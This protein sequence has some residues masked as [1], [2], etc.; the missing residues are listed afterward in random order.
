VTKA[1]D[2]IIEYVD[3]NGTQK[4]GICLDFANTLAGSVLMLL[5][6]EFVKDIVKVFMGEDIKEEELLT[7]K[8]SRSAIGE[9]AN[10]V[11]ASYMNAMGSYTGIRIYVTPVNVKQGMAGELLK[12]TLLHLN[13]NCSEALCVNTGMLITDSDGERLNDVGHIIMMPDDS[14]VTKIVQAM[15]I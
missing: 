14:S 15:D 2:S 10:I 8:D 12:E 5:D 4:V 13:Q 9:F 3:K 1:D 11:I 7:D 6:I